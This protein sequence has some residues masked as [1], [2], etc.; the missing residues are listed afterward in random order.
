MAP[1]VKAVAASTSPDVYFI[2]LDS[3]AGSPTLDKLYGDSNQDF[4]NAL[5]S[6]QFY[7]AEHS[8][9]NYDNTFPSIATT[10]NMDYV[11]NVYSGNLSEEQRYEKLRTMIDNSIVV[12]FFENRGYQVYFLNAPT[13]PKQRDF[14]EMLLETTALLYWQTRGAYRRHVSSVFDQFRSLIDAPGPKFVYAHFDVPHSPFVFDADCRAINADLSDK[15]IDGS[16][17]QNYNYM[18]QLLCVNKKVEPILDEILAKSATQP[19]IILEADHGPPIGVA[20]VPSGTSKDR[21]SILSAY[22]L[23]N[24]AVK[25]LYDTISPVNTFR[26]ILGQCFGADIALIPDEYYTILWSKSGKLTNVTEDL[27]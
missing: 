4:V 18:N 19:I 22:Y 9:S 2:V 5:K 17:K 23:P 25:Y 21:L 20:G 6:K 14:N 12:H 13:K 26:L 3:Y 10:L 7:I 16:E 11:N 1:P 15:K 27:K 8:H 24:S